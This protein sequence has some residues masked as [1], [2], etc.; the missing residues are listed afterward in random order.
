MISIDS[1]KRYIESE[2]YFGNGVGLRL[3]WNCGWGKE[4]GVD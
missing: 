4:Q 1:Y 2:K 3:D